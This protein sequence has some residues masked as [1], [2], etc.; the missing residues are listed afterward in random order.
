MR[1]QL[2]IPHHLA[3]CIFRDI[4]YQDPIAT[5]KPASLTNLTDMFAPRALL[6]YS[7]FGAVASHKLTVSSFPLYQPP[8]L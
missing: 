4:L 3:N 7:A 5:H 1:L 8:F 2:L 6:S